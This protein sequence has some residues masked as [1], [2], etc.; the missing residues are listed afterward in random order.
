VNIALQRYTIK[1]NYD[2]TLL[3]GIDRF[4]DETEEPDAPLTTTAYCLNYSE[5]GQKI[6]VS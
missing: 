5:D 4:N 6:V 1:F 3:S 2:Y